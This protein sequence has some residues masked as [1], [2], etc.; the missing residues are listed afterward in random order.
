MMMR[1]KIMKCTILSLE[2]VQMTILQA[3]EE[4]FSKKRT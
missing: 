1:S 4:V 3:N 2:R